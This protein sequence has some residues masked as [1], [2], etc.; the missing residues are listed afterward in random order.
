MNDNYKLSSY[1]ADRFTYKHGPEKFYTE[2]KAFT[3]VKDLLLL[4]TKRF[5]EQMIK[6]YRNLGKFDVF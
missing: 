6:T 2:Y 4:S 1:D 3:I 5:S